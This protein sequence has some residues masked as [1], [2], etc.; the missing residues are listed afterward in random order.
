VGRW[1]DGVVGV[2]MTIF[3]TALVLFCV[4]IRWK[5]RSWL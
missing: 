1:R 5:M 2:V 4:L 3:A